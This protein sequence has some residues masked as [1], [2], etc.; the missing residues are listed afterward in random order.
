MFKS[1]CCDIELCVSFFPPLA[2]A[3][4]FLIILT[5][6]SVNIREMLVGSFGRGTM[7]VSASFPGR[8]R[9]EEHTKYEN[10]KCQS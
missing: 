8:T 9:K 1:L 6:V 5:Q 10:L 2:V 7:L 3:H 4:H